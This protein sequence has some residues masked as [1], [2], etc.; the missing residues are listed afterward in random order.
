MAELISRGDIWVFDRPGGFGVT[1]AGEQLSVVIQT[2]AANHREAY[3]ATLIVPLSSKGFDG[4]PPHVKVA[5]THA[6][7]LKQ[8][9][10]VKTEQIYTV[11][12]TSLKRRV[13]K[14]EDSD[15]ERLDEALRATLSV[16]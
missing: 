12:K 6:N 3:K 2:N 9:G 15:L 10:Y 5:P 11:L 16:G 13:G 8:P 14:L 4:G 1:T 7:G